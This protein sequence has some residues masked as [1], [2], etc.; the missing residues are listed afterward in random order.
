MKNA[1]TPRFPIILFGAFDRHNFGDL[2]FPHIASAL[3]GET[4]TVLFAGLAE[5]DLRA[6]GGHHVAPIGRLAAEWRKRPMNIFHAGGELLTCSAWEAAVMLLPKEQVPS[7]I[8]R[9]D[10]HP[11][12]KLAWTRSALGLE[13]Y[14]PYMIDRAM[15]SSARAVLYGA[16]GGV[17]IDVIDAAMRAEVLTKLRAADVVLVRDSHTKASLEAAGIRTGLVPDPAVMLAELFAPQIAYHV[18]RNEVAQV[19]DTF[20]DGYLAVQFSADFGDEGT[21]D[22][23]AAQLDRAAARYGYGIVFFRAGAAPWHDEMEPYQRVAARMRT[24]TTRIFHSL[25]LWDICALISRSRAYC[26]S[27]LHGRIVA[28]ACSLPRINLAHDTHSPGK[29]AAYV[30][31]WEQADMP[32]AVTVHGIADA[33]RDALDTDAQQRRDTASTLTALYR[34]RFEVLRAALQ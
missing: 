3:L 16:V 13:A 27:S 28:M 31:T 34:H 30:E 5:R 25:H 15:F 18:Q 17:E 10:L 14:T 8:S 33:I 1:S 26:G 21:L 4:Q 9:Y 12:Q 2:L 24:E 23:I 11:A 19:L 22:A 29:L 32:A 6:C 7:A 20:P